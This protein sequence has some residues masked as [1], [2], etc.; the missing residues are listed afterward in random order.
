[1]TDEAFVR[2]YGT[3]AVVAGASEGLGAAWAEALAAR[4]LNLLLLARRPEV[5]DAT[6]AAIRGRHPGEVQTHAFDL[7]GPGFG[8]EL[9][10]LAGA[11]EVGFGVFNAA[12]APRGQFLDLT[13]ED[14]L[15]SVDVNC[16][17]PLT[18]AHVLGRRMAARGRG[19][20]VFM[21][22]LTAFHG[23]PFLATYGA[24]KA[25]NLVLG[26]GLWFELKSR[27]VD[28]LACA[29]GATRT[30]GFLRA[31]PHGE[32]GMIEPAQVVE[33]ALASLGRSGLMVPGRFNRFASFLMRRILP[34]GS[35]VGILGNR[36]RNLVLPP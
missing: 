10:R 19:G 12:H 28:V 35:A 31:S 6:A 2:R 18:L 14:Q 34:R 13:L 33:E 11:L 25:F 22:S 26:E 17:G 30:P 5:L 24:T 1:V 15:R 7:A 23:S 20:L 16:R 32:P 27:G 8:P 3:W 29:A 21:S 4:G 36:T 9:E